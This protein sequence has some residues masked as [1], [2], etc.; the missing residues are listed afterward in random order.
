MGKYVTFSLPNHFWFALIV[1]ITSGA[2][3]W[4]GLTLMSKPYSF[5]Y[6]REQ[7]LGLAFSILL[8]FV[9]WLRQMTIYSPSTLE[10]QPPV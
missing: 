2:L 4:F 7:W 9:W 6:G 3:T 8:S 5:N 1:M 10:E